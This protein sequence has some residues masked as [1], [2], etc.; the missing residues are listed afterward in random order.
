MGSTLRMDP[1]GQVWGWNGWRPT[2]WETWAGRRML[3]DAEAANLPSTA[4][5]DACVD[6]ESRPAEECDNLV[7]QILSFEIEHQEGF[8]RAVE[9]PISDADRADTDES[10]TNTQAATDDRRVLSAL[11]RLLK[12]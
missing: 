8:V 7:D 5:V 11:R 2:Y 1:N 4:E 3:D 6:D 9:L 10:N 12:E